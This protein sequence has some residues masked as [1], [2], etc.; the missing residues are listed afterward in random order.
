M[1]SFCSLLLL[2][3]L[4][5]AQTQ[6]QPK[7]QESPKPPARRLKI[8]VALSGGSALGLAHIGVLKWFED[9]RIPIDYIAGTSMGSLVGG[10][11][12]TGHSPDEIRTFVSKIDWGAVL[13]PSVPFRQLG[14]RRKEDSRE[15][16]ST[17]EL[18]YKKKGIRLPSGLNSGHGVGLVLS[19]FTAPYG[20]LASFDELSTPFRCVATDL[21][22]G[23][24]VD[25]DKGALFDALRSSMSLPGLFAPVHLGGKLLVDGALLNN[26]PVDQVK[27]M[28]A[29]IVIAVAFVLPP[30]ESKN[31]SLLGIAGRSL[32]VMIAANELRSIAMAD[33]V[34][35]PELKGLNGTDYAKYDEFSIRGYDASAKKVNMMERFALSPADYHAYLDN[36]RAKRRTD[37]IKPDV[38]EVEGELAPRRKEALVAAIAPPAGEPINVERLEAELTKVTG[39]GRFDSVNY[40]FIR[41]GGKERLLIKVNEKDYGPPFFRLSMLLDASR[42]EGF[43]FGIGGRFT[44]LD[45]GGPASEWRTDLSIGQINRLSTEYYYRLKGGKWFIAPRLYFLE[46]TLPLYV[47]GER[48]SDFLTRQTGGA[49][50][51]GYAFGRFQEFRAGYTVSHNRIAITKGA[52]AFDPLTGRYSDFHFRWAYEGQDSA[53]VPRN[54]IRITTSAALVVDHPGVDKKFVTAESTFSYA[55]PFNAK[56]SLLTHL[57]G[58]YSPMETALSSQ[59]WI[60]GVGRMDA[61]GRGQLIGNNYYHSSARVLRSLSSDSLAIF[62]RFYLFTGAE[63]GKAWYESISPKPRFSGSLG[64]MGE[65]AVGVVYFGAGIGD[66]GDRRLFFRLGRV[67]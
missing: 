27:K 61:L 50:D 10:L 39:M 45:I 13:A 22:S 60:G 41:R 16:P 4:A 8:G 14:Y 52:N 12:A 56:Y 26:I 36:R 21:N 48:T 63:V 55:R 38:I 20:N 54:G 32:S 6:E 33:L 24:E 51:A 23:S 40:S 66:H 64:L 19:R 18:G 29:D 2:S 58:G 15:Y 3:A 59:F 28:G 65:T 35:T 49:V 9:N 67:F 11:Y 46:D 7:A 17:I 53:L 42:Q 62:G 31:V 44:F 1:R 47:A 37:V 30:P 57:G 43:R 25:F 5:G 34:L